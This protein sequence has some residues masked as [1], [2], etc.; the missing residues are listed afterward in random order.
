MQATTLSNVKSGEY[1]KRK[2]NSKTTYVKGSYDRATKSYS[3]TDVDN[4]NK[5]ILI[6]ANKIVFIGFTY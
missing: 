2:E 6:K 1:I 5:E 4:I 3:C